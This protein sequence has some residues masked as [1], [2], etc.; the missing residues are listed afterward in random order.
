MSFF[1]WVVGGCWK[2]TPCRPRALV[3][4]PFQISFPFLELQ[5]RT[6]PS[7]LFHRAT[8]PCVFRVVQGFCHPARRLLVDSG[9]IM[10]FEAGG[11]LSI[12]LRHAGKPF[13]SSFLPRD[14]C[15]ALL[16]FKAI[17]PIPGR[18][19]AR[20]FC[21]KTRCR[22]FFPSSSRDRLLRTSGSGSHFLKARLEKTLERWTSRLPLLPDR[23]PPF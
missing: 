22:T 1:G 15:P 5:H 17:T 10:L 9:R 16:L 19:T 7:D 6:S 4:S 2:T 18:R 23:P 14:V 3:L 13:K 11:R 8:F 12:P 20:I 21:Y